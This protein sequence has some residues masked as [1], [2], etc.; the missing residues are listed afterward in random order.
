M[1][2]LSS[3][4]SEK[5]LDSKLCNKHSNTNKEFFVCGGG[6]WS[7]FKA[8]SIPEEAMPLAWVHTQ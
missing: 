6:G 4:L 1:Q 8:P 3:L 2:H 5:T 7:T